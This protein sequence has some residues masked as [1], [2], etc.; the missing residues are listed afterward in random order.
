MSK[1]GKYKLDNVKCIVFDFDHTLASGHLFWFTLWC[2]SHGYDAAADSLDLALTNA[3]RFLRHQ[4]PN[5]VE[6]HYATVFTDVRDWIKSNGYLTKPV[7]VPDLKKKGGPLP[8]DDKPV[9]AKEKQSILLGMFGGSQRVTALDNFLTLLSKR[10]LKLVISSKGVKEVMESV[11][12][13]LK[14]D[15]YF[16]DLLGFEWLK[17]TKGGKPFRIINNLENWGLKNCQ[18]CNVLFVDDDYKTETPFTEKYQL[19]FYSRFGTEG[20][21]TVDFDEIIDACDR[22]QKGEEKKN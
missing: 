14:L 17:G 10:Q 4:F 7:D 1:W 5:D 18:P 2:T 11:L 21:L 15:K 6:S 13:M 12:K 16:L 3:V 8:K 20:L 9:T 22:S 19:P